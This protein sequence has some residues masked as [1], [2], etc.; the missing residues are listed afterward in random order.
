MKKLAIYLSIISLTVFQSCEE[1]AVENSETKLSLS[2]LLGGYTSLFFT[3]IGDVDALQIASYDETFTDYSNRTE[4]GGY[5][6]LATA[7]YNVNGAAG[8][9]VYSKVEGFILPYL[10]SGRPYKY[11]HN[12]QQ[13][14]GGLSLNS[15]IKFEFKMDSNVVYDTLWLPN[16]FAPVTFSKDSLKISNGIT[17]NWSTRSSGTG[18]VALTPMYV[19]NHLGKP[20]TVKGKTIVVPDNGSYTFTN[21]FLTTDLNIPSSAGLFTVHL[22]R[23]SARHLE[24]DS[25]NK[26]VGSIVFVEKQA[27]VLID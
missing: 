15:D 2:G 9:I 7:F 19:Y 10:N 21:S 25:G 3:S 18:D 11:A 17:I 6:S 24:F 22:L 20:L 27:S 13:A 14:S 4:I 12:W 8:P 1:K 16:S 26:G 5:A 23:G